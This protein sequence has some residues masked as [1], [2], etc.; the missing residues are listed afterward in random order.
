[1]F[2][3]KYLSKKKNIT[4]TIIFLFKAI[5]DIWIN[6]YHQILILNK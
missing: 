5:S 3:I 6:V 4:P 1:V 2:S